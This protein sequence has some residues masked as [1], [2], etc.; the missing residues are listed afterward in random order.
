MNGY[1]KYDVS[2]PEHVVAASYSLKNKRL[3]LKQFSN[4]RKRNVMRTL[5]QPLQE[6]LTLAHQENITILLEVFLDFSRTSAEL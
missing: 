1:D 4:I 2:L 5:S 6:F 3:G